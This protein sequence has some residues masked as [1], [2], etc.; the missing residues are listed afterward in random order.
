MSRSPALSRFPAH[1]PADQLRRGRENHVALREQYE[2]DHQQAMRRHQEMANRDKS[3][4]GFVRTDTRRAQEA[5]DAYAELNSALDA[6]V[7]EIESAFARERHTGAA[8]R[9]DESDRRRAPVLEKR[10]L[11]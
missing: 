3:P 11:A 2:H 1:V 7:D 9:P 5:L 10:G 8:N 4:M 6:A